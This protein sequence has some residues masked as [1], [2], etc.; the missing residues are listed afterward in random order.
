MYL[1]NKQNKQN[2]Q[3][4]KVSCALYLFLVVS[5]PRSAQ[6]IKQILEL[7]LAILSG[8]DFL[9]HL[10]Y[11]YDYSSGGRDEMGREIIVFPARPAVKYEHKQ[12]LQTLQYLST[13]PR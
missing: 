3:V 6:D 8:R 1:I 12:I 7:K 4:N 13:I 2:K 9:I 10:F 5:F 11:N